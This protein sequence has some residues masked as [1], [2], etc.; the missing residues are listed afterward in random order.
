MTVT[1]LRDA[2]NDLIE[3]NLGEQEVLIDA[4]TGHISGSSN[5][6]I[7]SV[8]PGIDWYSSKVLIRPTITLLGVAYAKKRY[9]RRTPGGQ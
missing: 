2:L 1:E 3:F 8:A 6:S 5:A 9:S 7:E 4:I